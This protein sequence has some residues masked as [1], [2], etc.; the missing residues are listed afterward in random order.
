MKRLLVVASIP[1]ILLSCGSD[2]PSNSSVA[3]TYAMQSMTLVSG[4]VTISLLP[5]DV[6][7]SLTLT[8]SRY[9]V[10]FSAPQEGVSD[11]NSGT[12]TLS[13]NTLT[14]ISDA[15]GSRVTGQISGRQI[16]IAESDDQDG[17]ILSLTW[18]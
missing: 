11:S 6:T 1:L 17:L 4:G 15:D 8:D 9:T 5:P 12:Y 13:G 10:T 7:G 3:G 14:L 18:T 16:T 2:N